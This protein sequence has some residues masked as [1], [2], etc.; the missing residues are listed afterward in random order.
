MI[1]APRIAVISVADENYWQSTFHISRG[2]RDIYRSFDSLKKPASRVREWR[3]STFASVNDDRK[4]VEEI[5]AFAPHWVIWIDTSPLY[6]RILQGLSRSIQSRDLAAKF[7]FHVYGDFP[8]RAYLWSA[9]ALDLR[10]FRVEW[11]C[12][13]A[14]QL[15]LVQSLLAEPKH[16]AWLCPFPVHTADF[17]FDS[18]LRD[19]RRQQMG[20][21]DHEQ[22]I[23][24]A[25]RLSLQ[26]NPIALLQAY[27]QLSPEVM[28]QT[29]LIFAGEFDDLGAPFLQ[30]TLNHGGYYDLF[31][32]ALGDLPVEVRARINVLQGVSR[33][34][35]RELYSAAD[36]FAS[37]SLQHDE[38]FGM[39]PA[40]AAS[41]GLRLVLTAWG[42]YNSYEA[43]GLEGDWVDVELSPDGPVF[44]LDAVTTALER[45]VAH[46]NNDRSDESGPH[47]RRDERV[48]HA[49]VILDS[50]T[51]RSRIREKT[52]RFFSR[53][54]RFM[55]FAPDV[56]R[57]ATF[58]RRERGNI[59]YNET[60]A[61]SVYQNVYR[62]YVRKLE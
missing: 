43:V 38:D 55:G 53:T 28:A 24:Y 62:H 19:K 58:Y 2:L 16:A 36:I 34:E 61:K 12:A 23:F 32:K 46:V 10:A 40:E 52:K 60:H 17:K 54:K 51:V 13:S 37:L 48:R 25:G 47:F 11:A 5:I 39:A 21:G 1:F 29:K 49:C 35:L 7:R 22:V 56:Y 6:T 42:G 31:R 50:G 30:T 45:S 18:R 8:L 20:I 26:K 9:W 15:S 44:S 27:A 3:V 57:L 59:V 14:A 33:A 41:S 4:M